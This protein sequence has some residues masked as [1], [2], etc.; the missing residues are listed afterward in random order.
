MKDRHIKGFLGPPYFLPFSNPFLFSV[1]YHWAIFHVTPK[2]VRGGKY[3][4]AWYS[5]FFHYFI[6][7]SLPFISFISFISFSFSFLKKGLAGESSPAH[8][9]FLR[10]RKGC[11]CAQVARYGN[12]QN[13]EMWCEGITF[14]AEGKTYGFSCFFCRAK[15]KMQFLEE[16][17]KKARQGPIKKLKIWG[18]KIRPK[19]GPKSA[20]FFVIKNFL[21][22][23][24]FVSLEYGRKKRTGGINWGLVFGGHF[25]E[26]LVWGC[27]ERLQNRGSC[28]SGYFF[29]K[30]PFQ[31]CD[32]NPQMAGRCEVCQSGYTREGL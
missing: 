2:R 10:M 27:Q 24:T 32:L 25:G 17:R 15:T 21:L 6:L 14:L 20:F 3:E 7:L 11:A 8:P 18:D 31:K 30:T 26:W 9:E 19:S 16:K 1:G 29:L 4:R 23:K 13:S 28:G 12:R 5:H 22:T